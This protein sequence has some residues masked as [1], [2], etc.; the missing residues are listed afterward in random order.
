[1]KYF[2]V[3]SPWSTLIFGTIVVAWASFVWLA[4][5]ISRASEFVPEDLVTEVALGAPQQ[6]VETDPP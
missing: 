2:G 5:R 6:P 3:A 1:M 4:W